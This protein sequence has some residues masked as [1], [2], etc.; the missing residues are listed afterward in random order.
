MERNVRTMATFK[1]EHGNLTVKN[2]YMTL[3]EDV[4]FEREEGVWA[5][6]KRG[7]R[8]AQE[9]ARALYGERDFHFYSSV[10]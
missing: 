2:I 3:P 8:L 7:E 6:T 10:Y 5:M 9:K 1:D 4:L